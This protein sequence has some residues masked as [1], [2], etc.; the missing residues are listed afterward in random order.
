MEEY[1]TVF[2]EHGRIIIPAQLRKKMKLNPGDELLLMYDDYSV[3]MVTMKQAVK[4]AQETIK[5]YN[6]ANISLVA[7]N[8]DQLV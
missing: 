2:G 4:E 8:S 3:Y 6:Q 5:Q 7:Q 1:K